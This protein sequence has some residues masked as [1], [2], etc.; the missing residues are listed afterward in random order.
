MHANGP[1]AP[2]RILAADDDSSVILSLTYALKND[3]HAILGVS[4]GRAALQEIHSRPADYDM[5]IT[6]HAMD[7]MDGLTLV[8]TLRETGWKRPIVV[9]SAVLDQALTSA[10]SKHQVAQLIRKPFD[11]DEIR[12]AIATVAAKEKAEK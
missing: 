3:G 2:L 4:D 1:K 8:K 11:L 5:L 10:F 9:L 6:D 12:T 7:G